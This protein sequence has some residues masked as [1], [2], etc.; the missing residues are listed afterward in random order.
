M[1]TRPNTSAEADPLIENVDPEHKAGFISI[2]G[3]PNVGK[4]TLLNALLNRQLAA[5]TAKASTTRQQILGIRNSPDYQ[6]VFVDTP[7]VIKPRY[8][9][10]NFMMSY[11]ESALDSAD[12]VLLMVAPE[13]RYREDEL[14]KMLDR[15]KAPIMLIVNKMDAYEP[16]QVH[17]RLDE[18]KAYLNPVDELVISAQERVNV[19][20]MIDMILSHVP[21]SPPFFPKYQLSDRPEAFFVAEA[22]RQQIFLNLRQEI[23]YSTEVVVTHFEEL[24]HLIRISVDVHVERKSQKGIMIGKGGS[25]LKTIGTAARQHVERLLDKKVFLQLQVKVTE[26]WRLSDRDL[27]QMGYEKAI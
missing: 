7:G 21:Q 22:V 25:M 17:A 11:V 23:P 4:S 9:L 8:N 16:D 2:V 5:V 26:D 12:L 6:L 18:V 13:E 27:Q 10:H 3:K 19:D 20:G 14:R 24:D 1:H 15:V